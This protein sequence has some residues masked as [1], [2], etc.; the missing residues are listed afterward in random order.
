MEIDLTAYG[1]E[2]DPFPLQPSSTVTNW[3][4]RQE[5]REVLTDIVY[6]PRYSDIGSS[7][8]AVIHGDYGNGKSHSLRYFEW[9]INKDPDE[10]FD[11]IAVYVPTT[12]M[13]QRVSFLRLY[14]EVLNI[15]GDDRIIKLATVVDQR[16]VAARESLKST[17]TAEQFVAGEDEDEVL[18]TRVY[19]SV[20]PADR[21]MLR[22][23]RQIAKGDD[24]AVGYLRGNNRRLPEIGLPNPIDND[25]VAARSLG[26]LF[27]VL[28]LSIGGQPPTCQ[29]TYLFLDEVESTLED[30]QTDLDQFFQG[31]RN[32]VNELPYNFCLLLSFS[33]DT[34]LLEAVMPQP[35]LQRMTRN[36]IELSELVPERAKEFIAELLRENRP[37]DFQESGP[38]YPFGEQA[39][40]LVLERLTQITPRRL[41]R[42]LNT[43]LIRAIRRERLLSGEEIPVE[44]AEEILEAGQYY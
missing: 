21:P 1:L 26:G 40:E 33:S 37:L 2:K 8:F 38:F 42:I 35:I 29:A 41:F 12:K 32:L 5:E 24:E 14:E 31:I 44:L 25:F 11:S 18:E 30:R 13:T 9:M 19:E 15:I 3:A 34:A 43:I 27:R 23:V 17:L 22:L 36:Y 39:I 7:E 10:I 20:D 4:G 6:T 16:F 28:T